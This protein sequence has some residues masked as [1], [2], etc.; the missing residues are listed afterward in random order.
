MT[1]AETEKVSTANITLSI[2]ISC[3]PNTW[4]R[5]WQLGFAVWFK[6]DILFFWKLTFIENFL[7]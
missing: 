7:L 4:K 5:E 1:V 3:V 2:L 6:D